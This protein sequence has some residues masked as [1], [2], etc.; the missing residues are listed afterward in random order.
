MDR[1]IKENL[2]AI[3][4]DIAGSKRLG[5]RLINLAGFLG[6]TEPPPHI[7]EQFNRLSRL[8]VLQ[9]AFDALLEPITLLSRAGL[10]RML[11]V[12]ALQAMTIGRMTVA[13]VCL[14]VALPCLQ[15]LVAVVAQ[16]SPAALFICP[17]FRRA[18]PPS[19]G[20]LSTGFIFQQVTTTTFAWAT[21]QTAVAA[22]S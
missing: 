5:R 16:L 9:D 4:Q 22:P 10:S 21:C 8:V 6:T 2:E 7:Q 15:P 18:S 20:Q 14:Q 3:L 12:Q 17:I 13:L 19:T 1:L 11:D